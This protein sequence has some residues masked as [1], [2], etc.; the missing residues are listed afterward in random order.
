MAKTDPHNL[1]GTLDALES[2]VEGFR[3]ADTAYTV[4]NAADY[5]AKRMV[6]PRDKRIH[7]FERDILLWAL[8]HT[9]HDAKIM[10][11]GC[12]TGRLLAEA[13]AAGYLIDGV[14]GSGPMLELLKGKLSDDQRAEMELIIAQAADIPKPDQSYD[15]VYAVRLLNQ[16][17]SPEYALTVIDEIARLVK[18]GG[19]FLVEC[20]NAARPRLGSARRPT[21]RLKPQAMARRGEAA[22]GT[23]VAYRG[24]FLLSMQAYKKCPIPLLGL[25]AA[26]D[27]AL[28]RLLPRFCSRAYVLL[29]KAEG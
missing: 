18:P 12:G 23:V 2:N 14:D 10:E 25:F 29:R 20:V 1:A 17:E 4:D 27:R 6:K 5:D 19:Y 16:T 26:T 21:T 9:T 8:G 22:G 7:D 13:L 11:V 28:S 15:F 3:A 24:A